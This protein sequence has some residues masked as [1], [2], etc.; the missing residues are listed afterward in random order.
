M[1]K[2]ADYYLSAIY[3]VYFFHI[4]LDLRKNRFTVLREIILDDRNEDFALIVKTNIGDLDSFARLVEKY[5]RRVYR[6]AYSIVKQPEDAEDVTQETF[7]QAFRAL[8]TFRYDAAFYTWLYRIALN[9]AL[10]NAG[11]QRRLALHFPPACEEGEDGDME[12]PDG[13]SND[14]PAAHLDFQQTLMTVE[15]ILAEM[16]AQFADALILRVFDGLSYA[17]ISR[18][19]AMSVNTVRTRIFRAREILAERMH[20]RPALPSRAS[21]GK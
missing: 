14:T 6:L 12:S 20:I 1:S 11:R 19:R 9:R 16:P 8:P 18:A 2:N 13:V 15:R 4:K 7:I 3:P 10:N 21:Q 5:E 17:E